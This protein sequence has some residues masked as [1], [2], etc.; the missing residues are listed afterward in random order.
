MV[1]YATRTDATV[2]LNE[3]NLHYMR[4]TAK[5]NTF[6]P[7]IATTSGIVNHLQ[8]SLSLPFN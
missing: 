2:P 3:K 7:A 6:L 5:V 1:G 4:L 8:L